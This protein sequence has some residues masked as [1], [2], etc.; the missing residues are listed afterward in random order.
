MKAA[1]PEEFH[2]QPAEQLLLIGIVN[3][4]AVLLVPFCC[5]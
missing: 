1:K 5:A 3:V 2:F 4:I